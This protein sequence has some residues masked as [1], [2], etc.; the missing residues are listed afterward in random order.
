MITKFPAF[1][2]S[3]LTDILGNKYHKSK[4]II[5]YKSVLQS[6]SIVLSTTHQHYYDRNGLFKNIKTAMTYNGWNGLNLQ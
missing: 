3:E 4:Y 6:L 2:L 5:H 1:I